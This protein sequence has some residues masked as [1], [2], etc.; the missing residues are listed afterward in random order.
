MSRTER[1]EMM[2]AHVAAYN[3][4]G[5]SRKTYCVEHGL[6]LNV[7]NYWCLKERRQD[8]PVGFIALEPTTA[9]NMEVHYPNGVR[10]VLP[11]G[12]AV[13]QVAAYIRLY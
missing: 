12:T 2:M 8:E 10:L 6:N 13:A 4:S 3:A 5:K 7:M 9:E 11:T 1:R